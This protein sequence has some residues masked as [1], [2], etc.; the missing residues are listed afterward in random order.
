MM[1]INEV[2][3]LT[4][5]QYEISY[6]QSRQIVRKLDFIHKNSLYLIYCISNQYIT[7]L[8]CNLNLLMVTLK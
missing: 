5:N 2:I 8:V 7:F 3:S 4:R 6:I 1:N